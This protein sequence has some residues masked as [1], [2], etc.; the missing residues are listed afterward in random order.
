MF[1]NVHTKTIMP[2][3]ESIYEKKSLFKLYANLCKPNN[4]VR[5]V[6]KLTK[7]EQMLI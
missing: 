3:P 5:K 2:A 6:K 1:P 7:D 4:T